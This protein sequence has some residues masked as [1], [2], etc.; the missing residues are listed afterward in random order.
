MKRT[1][2]S[3]AFTLIELLVVIAIIVILTGLIVGLNNVAG[4]KAR[5]SRAALERDRWITLIE[6]YKL[7]IGG[8]PPCNTNNPSKN[9]LIYELA[10]A[11][12][13]TSNPADPVYETPFGTIKSS[14]LM[15]EFGIPGIVNASDDRTEIKRFLKNLKPNEHVTNGNALRLVIAIDDP[16]GN[17]PNYWNYLAPKGLMTFGIP[18]APNPPF[19]NHNPEAFDLWVDIK[20]RG[21]ARTIGNWKD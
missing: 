21:Q 15:N 3:S 13:N 5:I 16:A 12:R 8:Y 10:G 2:Q 9:T 11:F 19:T 14:D 18:P 1:F 6:A 17:R 7:K 20:T 4:E